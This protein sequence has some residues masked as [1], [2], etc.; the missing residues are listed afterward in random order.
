M[1]DP[2]T[3]TIDGK[4]ITVS[5]GTL[6]IRAA[7]QLGIEIPRFCDHPYLE[8]AGSCRQCYVE[9]E[10]QRKLMTSCTTPV[11]PNMG[12]RT[13]NTS[14]QAQEAQVANLEFL[15]LNHP[16]DCPICDRGGECPLQD[17]AL[18]FGPG[19]SRYREA[20]R[21][22]EKPLYLSPLVALDRERCVLCARCTRFCDQI[23]GDRFIEL[24]E[25]GAAEQVAIAPGEDFRS[26]FSGNTIQ[27]CPVGALTSVPYRFVARPFDLKTADSVCNHCSA[28]CNVRVDLRRGEVVRHLAR[29]NPDVNDL[30][31]CDKGRFAFQFPDS[32]DRLTTPLLRTPGLTP[33]SFGE[34]FG[35]I[36][37]WSSSGR[38]AFLAGG[39]LADED[40]YA[41]SK[42]ARVAFG[43]NDVDHRRSRPADMPLLVEAH[44]AA[45]MRVSNADVEA[46]KAIV[47]VGLDAEQEVPILHLRIRK[48]VRR[49]AKVFVVHPR[50]TRLWDVAEHVL[51]APGG[52]AAVLEAVA[53]ERGER[54]PAVQ[55]RAVDRLR[56]A[57]Q[58]AGGS[59]VVLAGTRLAESPG[60]VGQ[61]AALA[62][63]HGGRFGVVVRRAGDAGALRAGVHPALLPGGRRVEDEGERA[64]VQRVWGASVPAEPGRDTQAILEAAARRDI[65]VLFLVG[66]DPIRDFPDAALARRALENVEYKVV[67]DVVAGTMA[68]YADAALPASAW[69]EREGTVTNW[70]GRAQRFRPVRGPMPLSRPDW[71]IL[72]EL[73]ESVGHDMGF[74]SLEHLRRES[75]ELLLPRDVDLSGLGRSATGAALGEAA[76]EGVLLFTYQLLVDEGTLSRA[77]GALKEA[78]EDDAFVEVHP[79][80]AER[81][82][83]AEGGRATVATPAGSA[84]LPVRISPEIARGTAFVPFNQPGLQANTLLAGRLTAVATV[85]PEDA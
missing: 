24:F 19:E 59:V 75:A 68:P 37:R 4:E 32:P 12:V 74:A 14:E 79:D 16:L 30:W 36:A 52:E 77:A 11:A 55:S 34:A 17:Q 1:A 29:D 50:R 57:L 27:V 56:E 76:G 33:V 8:P 22:Y 45:G 31:T 66:V 48:A 7:E 43:T 73:S 47:V 60:A 49:G 85:T 65:D 69:V 20:K 81:L 78:L 67:Q 26:P 13:H 46:A 44:Q 63:A 5:G 80:D 61:A 51:V 41:L 40:A 15:L 2:V 6:I 58:E 62:S 38:V 82:G 25:R 71:Q 70:E 3:L 18:G 83:L 21:V 64:E 72:Q 28:G 54:P 23:S 53:G 84:A 39:R 42:L 35:Q 9:V 10:G